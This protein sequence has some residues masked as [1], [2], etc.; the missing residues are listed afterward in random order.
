MWVGFEAYDGAAWHV[1][2]APDG[3]MDDAAQDAAGNIYLHTM[4]KVIKWNGSAWMPLE[5]DDYYF[6]STW[7]LFVVTP[8]GVPWSLSV[9]SWTPSVSNYFLV[10]LTPS[11][12]STDLGY[13][14][15]GT[16]LLAT[17]ETLWLFGWGWVRAIPTAA[18]ASAYVVQA[19]SASRRMTAVLV[20]EA[21]H[22]SPVA[23][24]L[25]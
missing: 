2:P 25:R 16:H 5:M 24:A 13:P 4:P 1:R 17:D 22:N 10:R 20:A 18:R 21:S 6:S 3:S 14:P 9:V 12:S 8:S 7:P 19:P 23:P 11:V 15:T